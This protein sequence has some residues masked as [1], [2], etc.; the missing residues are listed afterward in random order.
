MTRNVNICIMV[1]MLLKEVII[2]SDTIHI[3][4]TFNLLFI[5]NIQQILYKQFH[6]LKNM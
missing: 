4:Q 6:T 1:K 3:Q 5:E 2:N